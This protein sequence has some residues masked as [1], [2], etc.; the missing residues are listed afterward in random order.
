M[1]TSINLVSKKRRPSEFHRRF[2]LGSVA[3][4]S[5]AFLISSGLIAYRLV[6]QIQL[7]ELKSEETQLISSVNSNPEKKVKFLTV[8]ERLSEI[9]N[10]INARQNLNTRIESVSSTLPADVG[11]SLIESEEET[12]KVRVTATDLVSLDA[13]IDQRIEQY[14]AERNRGVKRVELTSFDL[15]PETLLYEANF[16]IEFT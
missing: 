10:I 11:I 15:N 16:V 13:L 9:Q 7:D 6:L 3:F 2:F 4:F 12:V 14:A 5:I 8:R 1:K